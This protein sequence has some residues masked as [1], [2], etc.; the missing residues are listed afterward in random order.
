MRSVPVPPHRF[1]PLKES[2]LKIYTPIV[3]H[4]QL[5]VRM[6]VR[7]KRVEIKVRAPARSRE[8]C[9]RRCC[10][11]ACLPSLACLACLASGTSSNVRHRR[12]GHASQRCRRDVACSCSPAHSPLAI[13]LPTA[14]ALDVRGDGKPRRAAKVGRLSQGLYAGL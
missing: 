9:R 12:R 1:T 8:C 2:W 3:E 10:C 6:N 4:M 14:L 11:P 5:Q 13:S 7:A